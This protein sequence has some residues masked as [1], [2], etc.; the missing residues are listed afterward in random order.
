MLALPLT[1]QH[2]LLLGKRHWHFE[3]SRSV[4]HRVRCGLVV[5]ALYHTL[6]QFGIGP[7]ACGLVGLAANLSGCG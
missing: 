5:V 4:L 3:L 2:P 1:S 6:T 7:H